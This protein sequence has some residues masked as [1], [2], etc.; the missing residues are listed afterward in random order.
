[1]QHPERSWR[2][3]FFPSASFEAVPATT[4][5]QTLR[6][7]FERWGLPTAMQF[8]HGAPWGVGQR[9][10]PS[11]FELWLVG[12]GIH[13]VWS[14]R[15]CPQDNG[16]V[17]RSHR[18]LQAWSAPYCCQTLE[19]LQQWLDRDVCIQRQHY[20]TRW[21]WTRGQHYPQLALAR[22][23]YCHEQEAQ[24]W[25]LQRVYQHLEVGSWQRQVDRNGTISLYNRNYCVGRAL[26]GHKVWVSFSQ[27]NWVI[28]NAKGTEVTRIVAREIN[29]DTIVQLQVARPHRRKAAVAP[30]DST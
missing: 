30:L 1:M 12:L 23:S 3:A 29:A 15:H 7:W 17:E 14:R 27:G 24:Q 18:T 25:S 9:D 13:V 11:L 5:Q 10:L 2:A 22:P 4:V 26:A 28:C 20:P 6:H 21:G 19:Q 8:D 16:K